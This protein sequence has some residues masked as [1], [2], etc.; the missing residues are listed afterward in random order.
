MDKQQFSEVRAT[1][2][3]QMILDC[4]NGRIAEQFVRAVLDEIV[5]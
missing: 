4:R 2:E 3:E 5:G 1:S